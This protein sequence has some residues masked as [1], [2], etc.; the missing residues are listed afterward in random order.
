MLQ[1][2]CSLAILLERE[3]LVAEVLICVHHL[4]IGGRK[5]VEPFLG[6]AS[7]VPLLLLTSHLGALDG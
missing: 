1:G 5:S 6:G 7:D 2:R 3:F 4:V